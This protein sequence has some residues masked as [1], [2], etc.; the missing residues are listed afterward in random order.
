MLWIRRV[1]AST[2]PSPSGLRGVENSLRDSVFGFTGWTPYQIL[3]GQ[4]PDVLRPRATLG[5][6]AFCGAQ[7]LRCGRSRGTRPCS[8]GTR[9]PLKPGNPTAVGA[10]GSRPP[11]GRS[12]L[13]ALQFDL[14]G[15]LPFHRL[16]RWHCPAWARNS[17]SGRVAC[18]PLRVR[19]LRW[20]SGIVF[21]LW[22]ASVQKR[23]EHIFFVNVLGMKKRARSSTYDCLSKGLAVSAEFDR[24]KE[25]CNYSFFSILEGGHM[26]PQF[27]GG[28]GF[29]KR[30]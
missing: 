16:P 6:P 11:G 23:S 8:F 3:R 25:L 12:A 13:G 21:R 5:L 26:L 1:F 27:Y 24:A 28:V 10:G 2:R 22:M 19:S 15:Q 17:R 20:L 30:I 4:C 18:A 9:S 7:S 29:A 14:D